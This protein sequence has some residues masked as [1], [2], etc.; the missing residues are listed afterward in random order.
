MPVV[1]SDL[2]AY[3]A[4]NT[5]SDDVSTGGG[6]I[7][8]TSRP[9]ITPLTAN[10]D[11]EIVSTSPS[12]TGNLTIIGR[13]L[14]G[15]I[16][17]D[18]ITLTGTSV[19][20]DPT[21]FE[22]ILSISYVTTSAGT[23]T[24]RRRN[25]GPIVCIIPAGEQAVS[26]HFKAATAAAT[27]KVR[28]DKFFFKNVHGSLT[29]SSAVVKLVADPQA[30]IKIG[31][32]TSLN[33]TVTI[34]NRLTAPAGISF[35]DDNVDIALPGAQTLPAGS[36][37]GVWIEQTLAANAAEFKSTYKVSITGTS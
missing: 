30:N 11:L 23:I 14:T 22:R 5:P 3:N 37:I 19:V 33:D 12:D 18:V 27:T 10:D 9:L 6:A 8:T 24:V 31:L 34:T 21:V 28:Y 13:E 4:A 7:L 16:R 32:A 15:L 26:S 2:I 29:L 25:G 1:A 36:A 17:T 20:I 35:F